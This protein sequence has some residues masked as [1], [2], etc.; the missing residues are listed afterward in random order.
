MDSKRGKERY[1]AEKERKSTDKHC[2]R[3]PST[4]SESDE[5]EKEKKKE[6]AGVRGGEVTENERIRKTQG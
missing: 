3:P 2:M 6:G 4:E 5:S 1:S